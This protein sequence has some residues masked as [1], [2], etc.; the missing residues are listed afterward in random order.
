MARVRRVLRRKSPEDEV[1][2]C[3]SG[4]IEIDKKMNEAMKTKSVHLTLQAIMTIISRKTFYF[5]GYL[6]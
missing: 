2:N 6:A 5:A 3:L 4:I 1:N